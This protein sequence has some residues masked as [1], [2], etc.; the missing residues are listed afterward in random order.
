MQNQELAPRY[1]YLDLIR[2]LAALF[3]LS[4]HF[5]FAMQHYRYGRV[6]S[7]SYAEPLGRVAKY[8]LLG[9]DIFFVI[10]GAVIS[11]SALSKLPNQFAISRF[12]RLFPSF[13]L[14]IPVAILVTRFLSAD[15]KTPYAGKAGLRDL[16]F[17]LNLSNW[18]F[19]TPQV[20]EGATWTLWVEVRFYFLIFLVLS[21]L[22]MMNKT[23]KVQTLITL[24]YSWYFLSAIA[25][26]SGFSL[27][28]N[29]FISDYSSYFLVGI[30]IA[31]IA[32]NPK[33]KN[34]VYPLLFFSGISSVHE[35][36]IRLAGLSDLVGVC[37]FFIAVGAIRYSFSH[38]P[39][40]LILKKNISN[41]RRFIISPIPSA[42][43]SRRFPAGL[44]RS[45]IS[46]SYD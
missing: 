31:V 1:E 42:R 21:I 24:A 38:R 28:Q 37:I 20:A 32:L 14:I 43:S 40:N 16:I 5:G 3:V 7:L 12:A 36:Q 44:F 17:S 22:R 15:D 33:F 2:L 35:L 18:I 27:F 19:G 6:A 30:S 45:Q 9:V 39:K 34:S 46:Q 8:G 10:S 4:L 29:L 23:L 13:I 26:V 11:I 41:R 25:Q